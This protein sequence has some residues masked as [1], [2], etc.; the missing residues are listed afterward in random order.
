MAAKTRASSD[1]TSRKWILSISFSPHPTIGTRCP[2]K[3]FLPYLSVSCMR[4][5]G[6]FAHI[7]VSLAL[8]P[9][10]CVNK[11]ICIEAFHLPAFRSLYELPSARP[12]SYIYFLLFSYSLLHDKNFDGEYDSESSVI[13]PGSA[14]WNNNPSFKEHILVLLRNIFRLSGYRN[15][16]TRHSGSP[17]KKLCLYSANAAGPLSPILLTNRKFYPIIKILE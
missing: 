3:E 15:V 6:M 14:A 13:I 4:T 12:S 10:R 7:P 11:R 1:S 9:D 5:G 8:L 16:C 2:Y 17:M